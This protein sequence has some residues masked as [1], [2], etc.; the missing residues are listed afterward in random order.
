MT[1][2]SDRHALRLHVTRM[3]SEIL[4]TDAGPFID[5]VFWEAVLEP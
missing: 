1:Q 4:L 2:S 5:V 3:K